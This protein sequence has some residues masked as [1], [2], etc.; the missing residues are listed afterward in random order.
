MRDFEFFFQ[1]LEFYSLLIISG[2]CSLLIFPAHLLRVAE[3]RDRYTVYADVNDKN[4]VEV[5][6]KG[7]KFSLLTITIRGENCAFRRI[8]RKRS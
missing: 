4:E 6:K 7:T 3:H 1:G 2:K 5:E 8:L